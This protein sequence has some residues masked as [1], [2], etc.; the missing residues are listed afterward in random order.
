MKGGPGWEALTASHRTFLDVYSEW[1]K[2]IK[3]SIAQS[4]ESSNRNKGLRHV[5]RIPT[6]VLPEQKSLL[7]V[8][9]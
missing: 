2:E 1:E 8:G 4:T 7:A 6:T 5:E 9:S 3:V